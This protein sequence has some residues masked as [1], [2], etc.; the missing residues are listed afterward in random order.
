MRVEYSRVVQRSKFDPY[1]HL[2]TRSALL[3]AFIL[4]A[5]PVDIRESV[6]TCRDPRDN[7]FL[8]LA[9]SGRA[10]QLLTGDADLLSLHPWRGI[11]ILNPRDYLS[12]P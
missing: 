10:D 8:E 11:A 7:I 12:L 1:L 6:K 5:R 3:D 2:Q 4:N 9:L